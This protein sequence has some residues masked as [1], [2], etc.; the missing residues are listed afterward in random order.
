MEVRVSLASDGAHEA[1]F[2]SRFE[3]K[4]QAKPP[5]S[6]QPQV[7]E[8]LYQESDIRRR[9]KVV[10]SLSSPKLSKPHN[11][12]ESP[13]GEKEE[14][15]QLLQRK[16]VES[17]VR[18]AKQ[19]A[20][21]DHKEASQMQQ[22]P[23]INPNS[24]DLL[25]KAKR[26]SAL[27]PQAANAYMANCQSNSARSSRASI[28][29]AE[30]ENPYKTELNETHSQVRL[31]IPQLKPQTNSHTTVM[32]LLE[33]RRK[34]RKQ[35][36]QDSPRTDKL[37]SLRSSDPIK[38]HE[39]DEPSQDPLEMDVIN[40]ND[41]WLKQ[42]QAKIVAAREKKKDGETQGCT[43]KPNLRSGRQLNSL[44][45]QLSE[46]RL[47]STSVSSNRS[48]S[49]SRNRSYAEL[50]LS[51]VNSSYS[52]AKR[53]VSPPASKKVREEVL[54]PRTKPAL[55]K[56]PSVISS[57]SSPRNFTPRQ[58]RPSVSRTASAKELSRPTTSKPKTPLKQEKRAPS[59]QY[60]QL[61]PAKQIYSFSSGFNVK[62]FIQRA[63]PLP[64]YL[65]TVR[66]ERR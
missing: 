47:N 64:K 19:R 48:R 44:T 34:N 13:R 1:P 36:S 2:H 14:I 7:F 58:A 4:A 51:K 22:A 35:P 53:V 15:S 8:R 3:F 20:E 11:F 26:V 37:T 31:R 39:S 59:P 28:D 55:S 17:Q 63:Q 65:D 5:T 23:K 42:K 57:V 21:R 45:S 29:L 61:S 10:S 66:S 40:R 6:K 52:K 54:S 56:A 50:H 30:I 49:N 43:F 33:Q 60:N 38:V 32:R 9:N 62:D 46:R 16:H 25:E 41:Y 12:Q 27:L 18:L 24:K